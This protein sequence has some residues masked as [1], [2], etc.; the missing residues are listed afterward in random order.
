M[1]RCLLLL[2][3]VLIIPGAP[4]PAQVPILD[5]ASQSGIARLL[6][7][8]DATAS[9]AGR[10]DASARA[11]LFSDDAVVINAFSTYIQG[12]AAVDSFWR[13][14]YTSSTFD[15]SK[16]ERLD[17]QIRPLGPDLVLVDHLERLTG[18]RTPTSHRELPPRIT[19]ITLIMRHEPS[20]QW[21]IIYYRAGD[22]RSRQAPAGETTSSND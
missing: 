12:R 16:I 20:G 2:T 4:T 6:D 1:Q 22:Q 11:A 17:R 5:S 3:A 15:S 10:L 13:A 21:R 9:A 7:R 14:V 8:F 19:R 18:Q